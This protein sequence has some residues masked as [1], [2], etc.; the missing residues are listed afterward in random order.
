MNALLFIPWFKLEGIPIPG[1][2]NGVAI[3]PFGLLVAT[4]VLLGMRLTERRSR[5][6]GIKPEL[7]SDFI[8]HVVI[9]GFVIGHIFDRVFY[10]PQVILK[11][12][13]DLLMPW[14]SL[15]SYGGFFGAVVGAFIWKY[16]RKLDI[17]IPLDQVAFGMPLAWIFGRMGCFVVHDHPGRLTDFF[18]AVDNYHYGDLLV[19]PRHDLGLYEVFWSIAMTGLFLWLDRKPRPHGFFTGT[20]AL[21][22][23]PFR[24]GLDFLR[25]VDAKYLGLT[26]GHYSSLLASVLGVIV[27]IRTFRHPSTD[28]PK[29][30]R[31]T[32]PPPVSGAPPTRRSTAARS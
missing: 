4:G 32:P 8:S 9:I 6:L 19:G 27:L 7:I 29:E 3:Q 12:P 21:C 11:E 2:P 25:E 22:Y 31:A 24:F 18:L 23:G 1:L 10:D 5:R 16:R 17:T 13:W 15:S 30:L 28:I 26:P 20:I 14:R